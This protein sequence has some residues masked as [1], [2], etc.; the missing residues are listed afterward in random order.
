MNDICKVCSVRKAGVCDVEEGGG[1]C[2]PFVSERRKIEILN[3]PMPQTYN[4]VRFTSDAMD[5]SLP[6]AMDSHANCAWNC[7]Y[8]FANNLMR[9]PDRNFQ[10]FKK[11]K[12]FGTMYNE[13]PIKD[14]EKLLNRERKDKSAKV[15]YSLL[16]AGMPIQLGALGDPLDDLELASGWLLKAIP[17]FIKYKIPIRVSTKGG[18]VM[19]RKEYRDLF[20]NSSE[21]FWIAFSL[22]T[23]SDEMLAEVD[24]GAPSA[25]ARLAAM[26]AYSESGHPTSLR[27]RP[28]IPGISDS[29]PG[30]P[31][32]WRV[33]L[34][35][36]AESGARAVSFEYIFLQKA[37]TDRQK[38]MYHKM[39]KA[40]GNPMF[41]E[42]WNSCSQLKESC[43]RGSREIKFEQTVKIREKVHDLGMTF[44]ISDPHFK[45][46][47]DHGNCCGL[48][49]NDKWFGN[50]SRRQLTNV[51]HEMKLAHDKGENLQVNFIDWA[52]EW[53]T[54]IMAT[55][56][57]AYGGVHTKR[58]RKYHT[59]SDTMRIK[60]NTPNHARSPF[61]YFGGVMKP[62]GLDANTNDLVYEYR[63]W[64]ERFNP[65]KGEL[66]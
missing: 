52:P 60:W 23:I 48:P 12:E 66:R 46:F 47:N 61:V 14:L 38:V 18:D 28:F 55:E 39:F 34:E 54:Q 6:I 7:H 59:F 43:R 40:I 36:S 57:I 45:E 19:M 3:T 56:M 62:V 17:L 63:E 10:K 37:L 30:E 42:W 33:L 1:F 5:C 2:L 27:F 22:I 51:I 20:H 24:V 4:G 26:K 53:A 8:C 31:E 21:Q 41:G 65:D 44:G 11:M 49:E 29:V 16:D 32:A 58:V 35:K 50:W 13:Y 64:H 15:I 25:T 9:T